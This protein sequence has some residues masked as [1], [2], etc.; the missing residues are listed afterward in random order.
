M[1]SST[2]ARAGA[3]GDKKRKFCCTHAGCKKTFVQR[4]SL[5]RHLKI[6][7]G[8]RPY[9]CKEPGC[10]KAFVYRHHLKE[11]MRTHTGEK[12]FVCPECFQR[13]AQRGVARSGQQPQ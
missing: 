10:D 13:F 1:S 2:A 8:E 12:P 6:H 9:A 5:Q 7:S 3:N 11:H 4:G